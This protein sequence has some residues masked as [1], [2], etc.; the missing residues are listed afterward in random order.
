MGG[1]KDHTGQGK[2]T[3][4]SGLAERILKRIMPTWSSL[5]RTDF[6]APVDPVNALS[7]NGG[8]PVATLRVQAQIVSA[9]ARAAGAGLGRPRASSF[10]AYLAELLAS[11]LSPDGEPGL[12]RVIGAD[13]SVLDERRTLEDHAWMLR[14]LAESYVAT[15]AREILLIAD[16]IFEFLDRHLARGSIGYFEDNQ[17][18]GARRQESHACLLDAILTLHAATGGPSYL[19]RAASL[20]ELFRFHLI[21]RATLNIGETFDRA[22]RAAE[23]AAEAV[24]HP[25]SAA[26]WIALLRRYHRAS[27][28]APALALMHALAAR[29][30][31]QRNGSGMIVRALD[32]SGAAL[33]GSMSLRDQLRLCG[34]LQAVAPGESRLAHELSA[35]EASICARFID[36]AP[37]GCWCESVDANGQS[38]SET[39]SIETLATLVDYAANAQAARVAAPAR[40]RSVDAASGRLFDRRRHGAGHHRHRVRHRDFLRIDDGEPT[41]EPVNVD[42]VGDLEHMRHVVRDEDDRQAALLDVEDQFEHAARFL[43]AERGGR[44][45]E[46]DDAAGERGRARDRHALTLPA[47]ESLDRLV[48]VLNRHHTEFVQLLARELL[49]R[50][51]VES[52]KQAA[53]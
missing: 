34:A 31:A 33:D 39:I 28:D 49:H 26:H 45:V 38:R 8:G 17:G 53:Q 13:G 3:E 22:W 11:F 42:A 47:G 21:D 14:A 10:P 35:L 20:F 50:A 29:L 1:L 36:P 23:P 25:A 5:G 32:A 9:R 27:G 7:R 40:D 46:D 6:G 18:G 43:D 12:A 37:H 48:D 19:R 52:A 24:C 44:L 51:A 15:E 2:P 4:A 30:L 16:M 41:S